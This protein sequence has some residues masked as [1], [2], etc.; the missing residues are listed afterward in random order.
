[1]FKSL[2]SIEFIQ[3][4]QNQVVVLTSSWLIQIISSI[5][6]NFK[7][8]IFIVFL[9]FLLVRFLERGAGSVIYHLIYFSMLLGVVALNGVQIIFNAYFEI[10]N[11]IAYEVS[12]HVTGEILNKIK[13]QKRTYKRF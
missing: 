5:W 4:V 9:L 11:V 13:Q 10:I 12:Y 2:Y 1:M 8:Y 7:P 3:Q 6:T